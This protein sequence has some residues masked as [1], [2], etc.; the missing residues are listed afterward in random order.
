MWIS[1]VD[2]V[3]AKL[4]RRLTPG[5]LHQS[6]VRKRCSRWSTDRAADLRAFKWRLKF[7]TRKR[8]DASVFIAKLNLYTTRMCSEPSLQLALRFLKCFLPFPAQETQ[9]GSCFRRWR[10]QADGRRRRRG[11]ELLFSSRNLRCWCR[12]NEYTAHN[13]TLPEKMDSFDNGYTSKVHNSFFT[14]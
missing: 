12:N 1:E 3:V 14:N 13:F 10:S 11:T 6:V 5:A 4:C 8:D 2:V 9:L 7:P